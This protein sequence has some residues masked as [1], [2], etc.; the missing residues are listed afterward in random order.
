MTPRKDSVKY[1][2]AGD[3]HDSLDGAQLTYVL[4]QIPEILHPCV[5]KN[6]WTIKLQ[7]KPPDARTPKKHASQEHVNA[8][9]ANA[10]KE[11]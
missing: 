2:S 1:T 4:L 6:Q 10:F 9:S 5:Q 3:T 8:T 7:N 11:C